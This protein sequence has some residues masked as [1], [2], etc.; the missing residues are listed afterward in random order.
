MKNSEMNSKIKQA[1]EHAVPDVLDSVRQNCEEQKGQVIMMTQ[2]KKTNRWIKRI[3]AIAAAVAVVFAGVA[4]FYAYR[5][6]YKVDSTVSLD[7]NPSIEIKVNKKEQV[8]EVNALNQDA[9][10]IVD[11]MDFKGSNLDVTVNALIGSMLRNGYL[12]ELSNSILVSVNNSDPQKSAVLQEKLAQEINALLQTDSF[13][14][15]VLSQTVSENTELQK[16]ADTYSITYGKAQLIKQIADN[17]PLHTFEELVPLSINELNLLAASSNTELKNIESIGSASDKDYIGGDKAKSAAFAHA[18]VS[19]SDARAVS[20]KLDY[21]DGAMV[22]EVEFNA[23]NY[24]YEYDIDARTGAVLK[25][26]KELNRSAKPQTGSAGNNSGENTTEAATKNQ[27]ATPGTSTALIGESA[28][29]QIALSHAGLSASEIRAY[30]IELD[31]DDGVAVY[32]I[33]FKSGIYEYDYHINAKTGAVLKNEKERDDDARQAAATRTPE[34][35]RAPA[36]TQKATSSKFIEKDRAKEIALSH[37]GLSASEIREYQIE[38]DYERGVAVYEIEFK[39]G[40]YE[41]DYYINAGTG[42][43]LKS[44]KGLD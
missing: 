4:G 19:A 29:K 23:G 43:I 36:T 16:L 7:V 33:E 17:D 15:A 26:E 30:K 9:K 10:T 35:T 34:T 21:E 37:A 14:G 20:V 5:T 27:N 32:E 18:G 38:L 25:H 12:S 11:N 24:E 8:L 40:A 31:R 42:A 39:S 44:E 6:N 1:F 13:S 3:A 41:Y 2:P 22:Y 28:A